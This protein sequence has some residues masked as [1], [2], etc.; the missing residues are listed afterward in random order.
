MVAVL[1]IAAWEDD[2]SIRSLT[3]FQSVP[4]EVRQVE[5]NN[6]QSSVVLA[7]LDNDMRVRALDKP[8][9]QLYDR[10]LVKNV[11]KARTT[12]TCRISSPGANTWH[13]QR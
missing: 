12:T 9:L 1:L 8:G 6:V 7:M 4:T 2:D 13:C 3:S 10:G 5:F 11:G